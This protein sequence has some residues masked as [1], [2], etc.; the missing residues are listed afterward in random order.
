MPVT[1][2]RRS[3]GTRAVEVAGLHDVGKRFGSTIALDGVSMSIVEGESVALLG[4]NGAGKTT[5]IEILLGLRRPTTGGVSLFG[6]NPRSPA[7]R[8]AVGATPQ[9]TGL[10]AYLRLGEICALVARHYPDPWPIADLLGEFGLVD[11]SRRQAGGLSTGERRRLALAL[12]FVGRPRAVFLD[13]PTTGLDVDGRRALW[14]GIRAFHEHGGTV[15][16]TTHHL[17]EAEALATR[18]VVLHRGRVVADDSVRSIRARA[19]TIML[20]LPVG[21]VVPADISGLVRSEA[22]GGLLTLYVTDPERAIRELVARNV[23]LEGLEVTRPTLED[24][25]L[26]LTGSA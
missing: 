5:A 3:D 1:A 22:T 2:S 24:A 10:P 7:A 15:L 6:K 21:R 23:S 18:V 4:A 26:Y 17:D 20:R 19:P 9:E 14:Q 12:A 25:L 8:R 16:L 11:L 13:E